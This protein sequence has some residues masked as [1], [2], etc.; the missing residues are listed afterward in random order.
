MAVRSMLDACA[1]EREDL[2]GPTNYVVA[3]YLLTWQSPN[4]PMLSEKWGSSWAFDRFEAALSWVWGSGYRR[5]REPGAMDKRL[6][7]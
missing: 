4:C 2:K 1:A 7:F 3:A 5:S 6:S